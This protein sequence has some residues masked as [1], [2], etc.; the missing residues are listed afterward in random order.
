MN[1][2]NGKV[3][4]VSDAH[5]GV[6]DFESSRQRE[7]KLVRWLG[8][9][10][11]DAT[12]LFLLGDIFDYW[13]EY[14]KVIPRGY[15]RLLGKLAEMSDKGIEIYFFAGNH[16]MW[17]RDYFEKEIG[18]KIFRKPETFVINGLKTFV[19]HGD[20]LGPRDVGYKILKRIFES[21]INQWLFARLHPNF[22][23]SLA[24]YLSRRSRAANATKDEIYHGDNNEFLI[25][26]VKEMIKKESFDYFIFGHR[27][28]ALEMDID[29]QTK[30]INTGDWVRIFSYAET[31]DD[32]ISLKYFERE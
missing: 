16:D 4:F 27:H 25:L 31:E 15:V 30:Y 12:H 21:K 7:E 22:A 1:H 23:F 8:E 13:F 20:G 2:I 14:K 19:G 18:M 5:L 32:K 9:I 28:L 6:P 11:E 26:F 3:Y 10:K 24:Q 29:K 17:V